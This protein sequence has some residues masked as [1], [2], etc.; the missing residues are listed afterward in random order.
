MIL[1]LVLFH[2]SRKRHRS[3]DYLFWI[4]KSLGEKEELAR[5]D[6]LV[7]SFGSTTIVLG[8]LYKAIQGDTG[9]NSQLLLMLM[10]LG[11]CGLCGWLVGWYFWSLIIEHVVGSDSFLPS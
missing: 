4:F 2:L 7:D 1:V 3:G 9:T 11:Y 6:F 10:V 5:A 8:M